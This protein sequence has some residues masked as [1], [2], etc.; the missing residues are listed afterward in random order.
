MM[1]NGVLVSHTVGNGQETWRW[2]EAPTSSY[3]MTATNGP[4]E[5]K[6]YTG[7]SGCRCMTR[8]IRIRR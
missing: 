4:F 3:L 1:A 2:R 7:P 5:T 8:S 6:F